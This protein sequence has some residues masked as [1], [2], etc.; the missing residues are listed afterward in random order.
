MAAIMSEPAPSDGRNVAVAQNIVREQAHANGFVGRYLSPFMSMVLNPLR[1][2]TG[3]QEVQQTSENAARSFISSFEAKFGER[4]PHFSIGGP[5]ATFRRARDNASFILVYLHSSIHEETDRFCKSILCNNELVNFINGRFVTWGGDVDQREAY[6]ATRSLQA[7]TFP[8]L[9]VLVWPAQKT[10]PILLARIEGD[11]VESAE[12]LMGQL[13]ACTAQAEGLVQESRQIQRDREERRRLQ[14]QQDFAYN[15]S[16]RLDRERE[17]RMKREADE[18]VRLAE[19]A[20]E[21]EAL[22]EAMEMSKKLTKEQNY[23]SSLTKRHV[24]GG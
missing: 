15:E 8:F 7:A 20:E 9:A 1:A 17:E 16:L 12:S 21:A 18:R 22:K 14:E 6:S 10:H 19:E 24:D 23:N 11:K 2:V 3:A 4:H 13:A 5:E